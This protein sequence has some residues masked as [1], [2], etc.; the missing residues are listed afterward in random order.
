MP[1]YAVELD[2]PQWLIDPDGVMVGYRDKRGIDH[3]IPQLSQAAESAPSPISSAGADLPGALANLAAADRARS[4]ALATMAYADTAA[5]IFTE[6]WANLAAWALPGTAGVQVSG[7]KLFSTGLQGGGSGANHSYALGATENLRAVFI[8]N[9]TQSPQGGII[10]GVSQDAAGAAPA[11]GGGNAFGLYYG[12]GSNWKGFE[13]GGQ[14]DLTAAGQSALANG[15]YIVTVMVDQTYISVT[16][17]LYDGSA[18]AA[19]RR[20]R[21]GFAVNNL[22]VFNSDNQALA[23]ISIGAMSA[24]K[25]LATIAPRAFGEGLAPTV[26][27]TGAAGNNFTISVPAGYDSRRAYPVAICFH[28]NGSD[29]TFWLFDGNYNVM[30]RAL[31]AAGFIVVGASYGANKFTWG[32]A[33]SQAAYQAAYRYVRDNYNIG[34]VALFGQSMGGIE[35]LNTAA[36]GLIPGVVA[37]AFMVPTFSLANNF[38][39]PTFRDLI[40]STYGIA[41]DGSDYASK[42][43]G[44]DPAAMPPN[45]FYGVP[46][47]IVVAT[48]DTA[49]VPGA[50]GVALNASQAGYAKRLTYQATAGGHNTSV[51]PFAAGLAAF[52][53]RLCRWLISRPAPRGGPNQ[54][55]STS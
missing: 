4:S 5:S 12:P 3:L 53:G 40:R 16:A 20:L 35:S 37:M 48:D 44:F 33:V 8:L 38:A 30:T 39:N 17:C 55:S 14:T 19:T 6:G 52:L 41:A 51:A 29:E 11:G 18:V 23:G 45:A 13:N 22:Y 31:L 9:V 7:G 50:N 47:S 49:I 24:R 42:T 28:G 54:C 15:S 2:G 1:K 43:L 10:I 26:Q 46:M 27:W 21:A 25:S 36:A 32:A 34:A